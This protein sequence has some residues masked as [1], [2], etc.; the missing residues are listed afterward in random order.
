MKR[1]ILM[2]TIVS[3]LFTGCGNQEE[4]ST[5]IDNYAS[6]CEAVENASVMMPDLNELGEYADIKYT[7]QVTCYSRF[8]GFYSDGLALFVKYDTDTYE[9][10]KKKVLSSYTFLEEPIILD[11]EIYE[12]PVTEFKYNNYLMKI[13]PDEEYIDLNKKMCDFTDK[14]FSWVSF[15]NYDQLSTGSFQSDLI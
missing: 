11:S 5:D 13:V 9:E 1:L 6:D 4:I 8:M 2:L 15:D 7:H 3:F 12:I 10:E 14:A